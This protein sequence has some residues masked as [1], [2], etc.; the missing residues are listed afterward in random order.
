MVFFKYHYVDNMTKTLEI[1][2]AKGLTFQQRI[3]LP[4]DVYRSTFI[5]K[6]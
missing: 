4:I 2:E 1:K 3:A 6:K 5:S